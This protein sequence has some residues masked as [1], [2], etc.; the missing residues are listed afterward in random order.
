MNYI[1]IDEL[2][3]TDALRH[4]DDARRMNNPERIR[5]AHDDLKRQLDLVRKAKPDL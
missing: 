4:L 1:P 3:I 5:I 2:N